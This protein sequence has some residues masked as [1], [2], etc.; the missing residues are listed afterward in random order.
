MKSKQT[1]QLLIALAL[2]MG[3][4]LA[5]G[6]GGA[7]PTPTEIIFQ[8]D[9]S[10]SSSGWEVGNYDDGSVGYK[11][12]AYFVTSTRTDF[13]MWG[14]ANRSFDN[15]VIELDTTQVAAGPDHDNAY[16]VVCREQGNGDGYYLRISGDGFYSIAKAEGGVFE[17]LVDWT[18]S[19]AI[20]KG[21]AT[22]RLRI[23]CAGSTL[24]MYVDGRKLEE[25]QDSTFAAGDIA[26][27]ATT[28]ENNPTEIHFDNLVVS[29][30]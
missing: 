7:E 20:K 3:T 18:E 25:V 10:N 28:Y 9:F 22:N 14:V 19:S 13:V 30:P 17:A 4:V 15:C 8:D 27:T 12:G 6:G 24:A 23:E 1:G 21:N 2:L 5:C 11:E 16:G 29:K 26:L